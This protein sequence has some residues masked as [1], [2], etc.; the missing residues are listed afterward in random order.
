MKNVAETALATITATFGV[1]MLSIFGDFDPLSRMVIYM[2]AA[3]WITGL[4]AAI[5]NKQADA[6]KGFTGLMK[7]ILILGLLW[8]IRRIDIALNMAGAAFVFA[9]FFYIGNEGL[10]VL[11]NLDKIGVPLPKFITTIFDNLRKKGD[12]ATNEK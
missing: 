11:K 10:S 6:W 9:K 12:T 3:D 7:K 5:M 4:I 8:I 1:I 2:L